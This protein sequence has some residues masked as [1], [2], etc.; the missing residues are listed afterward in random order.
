M[1]TSSFQYTCY[2]VQHGNS[3]QPGVFC[4]GLIKMNWHIEGEWFVVDNFWCNTSYQY[5]GWINGGWWRGGVH[6][7][8]EVPGSG[9]YDIANAGYAPVQITDPN[10]SPG[11]R[12]RYGLNYPNCADVFNSHCPKKFQIKDGSRFILWFGGTVRPFPPSQNGGYTIQDYA[13]LLCVG[14]PDITQ[15]I[16]PDKNADGTPAPGFDSKYKPGRILLGEWYSCNRQGGKAQRFQGGWRTTWSADGG[17]SVSKED[18][19]TYAD[20]NTWRRMK[21][22]GKGG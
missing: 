18:M 15:K 16:P 20:G 9:K 11:A 21:K 17:K 19:D 14:G 4:D 1:P 8:I 7:D 2:N 13:P 12:Q 22:I 5:K 6:V 3:Y 10:I